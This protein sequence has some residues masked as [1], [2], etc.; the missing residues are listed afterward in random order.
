MGFFKK[1]GKIAENIYE[2]GAETITGETKAERK[3]S[4]EMSEKIRKRLRAEEFK[5]R[6]KETAKLAQSKARLKREKL[7]R[8]YKER[9]QPRKMPQFDSPFRSSS[10]TGGFG[11]LKE[12]K[13]KYKYK[14]VYRKGGGKRTAKKKK[15]QNYN[16]I[17]GRFE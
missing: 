6:E 3:E 4:R 16:P 7:E 11:K 14:T 9:M 1:A 5:A 2:K 10:I 15:P 8:K 13:P 12:K 17:T